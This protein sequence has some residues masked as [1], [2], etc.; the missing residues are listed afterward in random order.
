MKRFLSATVLAF[1]T[2]FQATSSLAEPLVEPG[3]CELIIAARPTLEEAKQV[4]S[5]V[6]D[7]RFVKIFQAQNG[8][9]AISIGA[10]RPDEEEP[11]MAKWK[12]SGKIPQDAY[13]STGEKYVSG[14][15]WVPSEPAPSEGQESASGGGLAGALVRGMLGVVENMENPSPNNSSDNGVSCVSVAGQCTGGFGGCSVD[16]ISLSGGPGN[17]DNSW[18]TPMICPIGQGIEGTYQYTMQIGNS[19]CSGSFPV[20]AKARSGIT[21]DVFSDTCSISFINEY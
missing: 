13:C 5:G 3:T 16:K 19:I 4:V 7:K 21:I 14:M 18:H 1:S 2:C 6:T 20:T 12:A 10:L 17:V 9:Y 11:I 15:K 8:W